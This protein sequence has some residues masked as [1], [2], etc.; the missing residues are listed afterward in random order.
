MPRS[1]L[2]PAFDAEKAL[3]EEK[4]TPA[5]LRE[6]E[7][8]EIIVRTRAV[9]PGKDGAH[10]MAAALVNAPPER[11]IEVVLDCP[12]EPNGIPHLVTCSNTY[13]QPASDA[14]VV[15]YEQT[16]KLRFGFAFI[17]KEV[18]YTL[19]AFHKP[20]YVRGWT[21]KQGDIKATEGY[22]RVIPYKDGKQILLYSVYSDP[23][24]VLPDFV[25]ETLTKSDLPKNVEA[26]K[27]AAE[28][29]AK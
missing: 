14:S 10:I 25:Q 4:L 12:S 3:Q 18:S 8:G 16:E 27:K 17:S 28:R 22:Y 19:N 26:Y 1:V 24:T 2:F 5:D 15:V 11:I 9:P 23:G 13:Q 29:R 20:P 7:A 21:L 6:L